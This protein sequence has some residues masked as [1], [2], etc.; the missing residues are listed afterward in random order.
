MVLPAPGLK[1]FS[2][3]P[4][5]VTRLTKIYHH[6]LSFGNLNIEIHRCGGDGWQVELSFLAAAMGK[7][8][9]LFLLPRPPGATLVQVFP[10]ALLLILVAGSVSGVLQM[11]SFCAEVI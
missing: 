8:V 7:K 5:M 1:P 11:D 9:H 3:A 6:F 2:P 10:E 4:K